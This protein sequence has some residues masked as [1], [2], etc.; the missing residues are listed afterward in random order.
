MR[1]TLALVACVA[2]GL[3]TWAA[4]Q[5][6]PGTLFTTYGTVNESVTI[7]GASQ[8]QNGEAVVSLPAWFEDRCKTEGRHVLLTC[9]GGW[10][11]LWSSAVSN[12]QFTVQTNGGGNSTQVFWWQVTARLK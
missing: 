7:T 3:A 2:A 8:L 9:K 11:P 10:S 6:E 12:G 1:R 5:D 4:A